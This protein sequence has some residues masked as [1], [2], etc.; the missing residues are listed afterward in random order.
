MEYNRELVA[1]YNNR[2]DPQVVPGY[3]LAAV[4]QEFCAKWLENRPLLHSGKGI[5]G[6]GFVGPVQFIAQETGIN[7]RRISGFCNSEFPTV[8]FY[9]AEL[10]LLA[11]DREYLLS[12][13][14]IQVV[15]NPNWDLEDYLEWRRE[16]GCV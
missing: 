2:G 1:R 16:Q 9:Q 3:Q 12:N 15:P 11:I 7:T 14:I 6:S 10:V 4:L 5:K 8:S 13:G